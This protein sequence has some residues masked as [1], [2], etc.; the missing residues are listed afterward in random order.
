MNQWMSRISS[1]WLVFA[2]LLLLGYLSNWIPYWQA[3]VYGGIVLGGSLLAFL[4]NG[5]DKQLARWNSRRVPERWMHLLELC[6]GWPGAFYGQQVFRH[7]TVKPT[8]RRIFWIM[9]LSHLGCVSVA[10]LF[11]LPSKENG[12]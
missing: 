6:G 12:V 5:L 8:Y 3:G 7:K 9:V 1:S 4:L 10:L 2:G 11:S